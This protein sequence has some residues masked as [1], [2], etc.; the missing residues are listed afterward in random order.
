MYAHTHARTELVLTV[1]IVVPL[2]DNEALKC[3]VDEGNFGNPVEI[4]W[5]LAAMQTVLH[6]GIRIQRLRT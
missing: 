1:D 4:D 6:K 3:I 5:E 2:I